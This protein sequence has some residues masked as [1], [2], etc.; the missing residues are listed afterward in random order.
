MQGGSKMEKT[1]I[2][3][4]F[5]QKVL[6]DSLLALMKEKSIL[7]IS[8]KEICELAGV[9]RSTFYIYY[10]DQYDL[11]RQIEDQTFIEAD[12]I[13]QP[14]TKIAKKPNSREITAIFQDTLQFIANNNNS[15][16]VLLGE[17]GDRDFQKKYF[18]NSIESLRK[19]TEGIGVKLPDKKAA[20]YGFVFVI[21][22]FHTLV[23][24]WLKNGM[25]TPAPDLAKILTR[26]FTRELQNFGG[27]PDEK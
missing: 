4:R 3:V 26:F 18:R 15:I 14:H 25:D 23:Q 1:D 21:G 7:A 22:G 9:S 6:R 24:E 19:F 5:T 11:L 8:I 16:Q 2:R 17:N 10:K 20:Q 13:I 27:V 12:K